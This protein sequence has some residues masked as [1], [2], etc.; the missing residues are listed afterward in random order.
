M[1][2]GSSRFGPRLPACAR[3]S[4]PCAAPPQFGAMKAYVQEGGSLLVTLG[5]GG[6]AAF[7]TN[8]N[9]SPDP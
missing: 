6:E 8:S 7:G 4:V 2:R 9:S 1:A 3:S 5:E